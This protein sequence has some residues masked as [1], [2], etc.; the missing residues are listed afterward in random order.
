MNNSSHIQ[1]EQ[2]MYLYA[3]SGRDPCVIRIIR[4]YP[5]SSTTHAG[6]IRVGN[7]KF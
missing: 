7:G 6:Y 4:F 5:S 2:Q 3:T 1:L